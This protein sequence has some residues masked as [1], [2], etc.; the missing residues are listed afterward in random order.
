MRRAAKWIGWL[1]GIVVGLAVL[2]VAFV[3]IAANTDTG[4]RTIESLVPELTGDTVRMAD[5]GGR[6]PDALRAGRIELRDAAGDYATI[7]NAVFD[8]SPL[9]L[10]HWHIVIDRLAAERIDVLR[11]PVSSSSSS[12]SMELPAPVTLRQ[13]QLARIDIGAP[14]A[15]TPVTVAV[16]GSGAATSPTDFQL[17]LDVRQIGGA[18]HYSLTATADRSD[19]DAKI[20]ASEPARGLVASLAGLPDIGDLD[21]DASLRGPRSAAVTHVALTAGPLHA[22]VGGTVDVDHEAADLMVSASAPAMRPRPDIAWQA[23]S[24]DAHVRGPLDKLDATGQLRIDTLSAAGI[25]ASSVTADVAGNAG[26]LHLK[27]EVAGLR[28]PLPDPDIFAAQPVAIEADAKLDEPDLPVD[29]TLRHKLFALDAKALAGARREVNATL[30][31]PDLSP[32]AAMEKI[33]I[34]G[35]LALTLHAAM[36][37][38][39]TTLGVDGTV[40][41]T[42]GMQQAEALIGNAGKLHLAAAVHGSDVT[43]SDLTFT[44]QSVSVSAKGSVANNQ[45][46]LGWTLGVSDLAAAEPSLQGQLQATGKVSGATDDLSLTTDING[47]VATRGYSSGALTA[48]I[49]ASGLPNN[50]NGRITVQGSLLDAPVDLAVAMRRTSDGLA[51]DIQKANWKSLDAGGALQMPMATMVPAGDLHVSMKRLADLEPLLRRKIAGS[52]EAALNA[53]PDKLHLTLNVDGVVVA[54]TASASRVAL[55]ADVDQP[56]SHPTLDARLTAEGIKAS[57]VAGSLKATASGPENAV[58]VKLSASLPELSGAPAQLSAEATVDAIA[59]TVGIASFAGEWHG[60]P[61][62][63]LAPARV[64][65]SNG[66]AVDRLRLGLR[67]AVLDMSGRVGSTLDVTAS[68]RNLPADIGAVLSPAYAADGVIEAD[69]RITGT[70]ARPGGKVSLKATGLRARTGPGRAAPPANIT[71]SATLEGTSANVDARLAAGSSHLAVTGRAPLSETGALGLRADGLIDLAV[72]D[73]ILTASGRRVQGKVTLDLTIS[74]TAKAPAVAGTAQLADGEVQD[75]SSG[76]HLTNMTAMLQ[77]SGTTLRIVRFTANA[78]S[79]TINLTGTVGVMA[80]DLPVDLTLTARDAQPLASDQIS[81]TLDADMTIRGEAE[82]QLTVGGNIHV[83]RAEARVPDRLPTSIAVL[84]VRVAGSKPPPP[85]PAATSV[86][87]LNL[88]IEAPGQVFVRG[89]GLDCEFAGS[90]RVT[91]TTSD[92]KTIGALHMRRGSISLAGRTLTFTEGMIAFNGGSLSDPSLHLVATSTTTTVVATLSIDGTA[93]APKITLSSVP[94]LPQDEVLSYLLFGSGVGK[95]GALEV[96]E[97]AAGL[98]SL[99]GTGG[100][101]G[102]PLNAVRQGLGLDRLSVGSSAKGS[103]TLEAGRY[104]APGVYLG[105][106]QSASGGGSQAVVQVDIAKGLKLQG[107]AGTGSNSAT[108]AAGASSGTSVGLTYQFQY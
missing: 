20:T 32:F 76:L 49:A 61:I 10:V 60:Q 45:V 68:L 27:G 11:M 3:L 29:L 44:G 63:L 85:P 57:G 12:S 22:T 97:I 83:K 42:G 70:T 77:G 78:G 102:D 84:P 39:T 7:D 95:L 71:A 105:A 72:A 98:A 6:F 14:V 101:V 8:W 51:V 47:G 80:P 5:L 86:I 73:P 48:H 65:F 89:R 1:I 21:L 62:R 34:A 64:S 31:A 91:G 2:L 103:P 43:L 56:E 24:L 81:A 46:D 106:Q 9:Q 41:V 67:Q 82:G 74:G 79:G 26:H 50:P 94:A 16:S 53:T 38:D 90:M 87:A 35:G 15:G 13:L 92:P 96:A 100:S 4:R 36:Q 19:L 54:G 23:V 88:T 69:A 18:G 52:V 37:G 93:Q 75:F 40:G 28:V 17:A 25:A 58:V 33:D 55:V 30:T 108:G 99:T 59:R 104:V 66:V 107:T